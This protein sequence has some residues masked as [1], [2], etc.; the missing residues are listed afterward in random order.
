MDML[1]GVKS[2]PAVQPTP[3]QCDSARST[4]PESSRK[5]G[6][7]VQHAGQQARSRMPSRGSRENLAELLTAEDDDAQSRAH[8]Q[9][10]EFGL[11]YIAY[12]GFLVSRKNYGFWLRSIISE[13]GYAKGQAG[14]LGSTLEAT[15]GTCSFLNGVLIDTRSPKHLLMAGLVL[16]AALNVGVAST[17][18]LAAMV[19]LWGL[20][21]AVQSVGWPSI[22]NVFLARFP[23]P[24]ARGAWY[25]LLSTCQNAGAALVPLL[26]SKAVSSYGWRAALFAPAAVSTGVAVLLA[27]CLYGSPKAVTLGSSANVPK[28]KPSSGEFAAT[29]REQVFLNHRLW[30]M[31]CAYFGVSMVRTC[32]QDWTSLYL[33][34]AKGLPLAAAARC[35][36]L[37]EV[38]GFAGTFIAGAVSDRVFGG[39]RGP[40]VCICCGVLAPSLLLL[41]RAQDEPVIQALYLWLGFCA[42]PVHV[43]LGLFSREVVPPAVS[44]TAGGFV[45]MIAQVGGASAGYPLGL[46]QQR[47][48]WEGV[49]AFL[50]LVAT[51]AASASAPLWR[52]TA[53]IRITG[54]N[55]TVQDFKAMQR[56]NSS[57]KDLKR[58]KAF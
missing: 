6:R 27:L 52:T 9:W 18:S 47:W 53:S 49:F 32:L 34:E 22:T 2:P 44:S 14:L 43:L 8:L 37:W 7:E 1:A 57:D 48:G 40:V 21:G 19:V 56:R 42:F 54:R 17:D 50:A 29:M 25:S 51:L 5:L 16:S 23:D 15:Y 4:S 36:F 26:V 46:M 11:I 10:R 39:R 45:K 13:Y 24:A 28:S 58:K 12:M 55:G 33:A 31:A 30:M 38:G 41:L 20:N 3:L 35:L